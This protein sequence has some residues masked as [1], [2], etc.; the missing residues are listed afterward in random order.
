MGGC[1]SVFDVFGALLF[2][3]GLVTGTRFYHE[4]DGVSGQGVQNIPPSLPVV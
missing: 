4:R 3:R 1:S 2:Q